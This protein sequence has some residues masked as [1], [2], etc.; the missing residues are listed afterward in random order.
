MIRTPDK[1]WTYAP[2]GIEEL[3]LNPGEQVALFFSVDEK[4]ELPN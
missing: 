1:D 3:V 2:V 4:L